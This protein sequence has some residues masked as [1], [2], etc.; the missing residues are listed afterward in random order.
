MTELW[1]G[2]WPEKACPELLDDKVRWGY[3]ADQRNDFVTSDRLCHPAYP[4]AMG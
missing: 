3:D 1:Q 2:W 4:V